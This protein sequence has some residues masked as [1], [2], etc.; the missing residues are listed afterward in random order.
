[1][2]RSR[3]A[4]LTQHDGAEAQGATLTSQTGREQ[5][6]NSSSNEIFKLRCA[7][8][9]YIPKL[10]NSESLDKHTRAD[11]IDSEPKFYLHLS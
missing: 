7:V 6:E 4:A 2:T 10:E 3:G 9:T 5:F 1:M 8:C 11:G